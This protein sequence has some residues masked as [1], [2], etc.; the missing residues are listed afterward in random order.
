MHF[1]LGFVDQTPEHH[2]EHNERNDQSPVSEQDLV[3]DAHVFEILPAMRHD[4]I[5]IDS[6]DAQAGSDADLR[7][8]RRS[9][10]RWT[11]SSIIFLNL[12]G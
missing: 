8:V 6:A 11:G 5:P 12:A 9:V 3:A 1:L 4:P 7:E 2:D 10:G